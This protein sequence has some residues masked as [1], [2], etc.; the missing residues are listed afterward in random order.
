MRST[1]SN[2]ILQKILTL[3]PLTAT[4]P[5]FYVAT[6]TTII[7]DSYYFLVDTLNHTKYIKLKD[8]PGSD[9]VDC[10]DAILVNVKSLES[11]GAFKPKYLRYIIHI[12]ENTSNS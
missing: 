4:G 7:S 10:Y 3:V 1:F 2:D 5:E 12:F 8:H 11:D 6:M 9:A